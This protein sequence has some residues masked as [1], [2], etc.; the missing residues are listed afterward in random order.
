M[1]GDRNHNDTN[2]NNDA[3]NETDLHLEVLPPHLLSHSVGSSS[4]TLCRHRQVIGL[5]LE[6]VESLSSLGDLVDVLSH[7]ADSVIDL[8]G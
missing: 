8:L 6:R 1:D 2:K 3:N 4:E 5:V 7:D